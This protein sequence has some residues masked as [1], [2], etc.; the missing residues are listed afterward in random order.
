[1]FQV[2][3]LFIYFLPKTYIYSIVGVGLSLI[4][5]NA[6]LRFAKTAVAKLQYTLFVSIDTD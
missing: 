5:T 4:L 1:M 3:Y 2:R 6:F